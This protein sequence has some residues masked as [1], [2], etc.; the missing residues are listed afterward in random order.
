MGLPQVVTKR[1]ADVSPEFSAAA[2][3]DSVM[4]EG[5]LTKDQASSSSGSDKDG[6]DL[7][8]FMKALVP[9]RL[10]LGGL[11]NVLDGVVDCPGRML[12]LT[13]NHPEK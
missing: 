8:N 1:T 7:G 4:L 2:D 5:P 10:D 11:L 3:N 9:D 12:I 13:S 6:S